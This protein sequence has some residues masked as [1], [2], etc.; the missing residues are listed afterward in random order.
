MDDLP[1]VGF[2]HGSRQGFDQLGGLARR[3]G[4]AAQLLRQAAA[5]AE[6]QREERPALVFADAVDLD[7]VGVVQAGDG[8]GLGLEAG[9]VVGAGV[10]ARQDHLERDDAVEAALPGLVD[11]AHAAAADL[12]EQ[13]VAGDGTAFA[14]RR[15]CRADGL[16]GRVG[17]GPGQ[18]L[19]G[20]GGRRRTLRSGGHGVTLLGLKISG[21]PC[22]FRLS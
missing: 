20:R 21:V 22:A 16:G 13:L 18:Q 12:A 3:Q 6:F 1:L 15:A 14:E 17:V 8:L 7:D 11:D 2:V 4:S 9:Q 10:F 19:G 5:A